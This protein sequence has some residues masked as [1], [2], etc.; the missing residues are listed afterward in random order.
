MTEFKLSDKRKELFDFFEVPE[1]FRE[2]INKQDKEFIS[3]L[4]E[5]ITNFSIEWWD[6][7]ADG[8]LGEDGI[9]GFITIYKGDIQGFNTKLIKRFDKLSGD[10]K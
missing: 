4:K 3:R 8:Y 9:P 2:K 6:N 7:Q 10:L 1:D 5:D